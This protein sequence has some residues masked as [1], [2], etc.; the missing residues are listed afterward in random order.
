MIMT[1]TPLRQKMIDELTLRGYSPKTFDSYL[2][3]LTKVA[4]HYNRSPNT[5]TVDE[6]QNWIL[7]LINDRKLS[8]SSVSAPSTP[9]S[10]PEVT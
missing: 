9:S 10:Y 8:K 6:I 1:I 3:A 4:K 2:Y 5:L 7:Y